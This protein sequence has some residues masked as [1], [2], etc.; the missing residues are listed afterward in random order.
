MLGEGT[1]Q[2][3]LAFINGMLFLFNWKLFHFIG[4][5][6]VENINKCLFLK[7]TQCWLL[8]GGASDCWALKQ[9]CVSI[10][11]WVTEAWC[12]YPLV[13]AIQLRSVLLRCNDVSS[14]L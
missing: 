7:V 10:E 14:S 3:V 4:F 2:A 8:K 13:S 12:K 1:W 5:R 9:T 11:M 6:W